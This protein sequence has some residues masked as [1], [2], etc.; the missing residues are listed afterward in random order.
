AGARLGGMLSPFMVMLGEAVGLFLAWMVSGWVFGLIAGIVSVGASLLLVRA[1]PGARLA[2]LLLF[3]GGAVVTLQAW[4]MGYAYADDGGWSECQCGNI[5]DWFSSAGAGAVI[6]RG[7]IGG[8]GAAA[9]ALF[10]A[11]VGAG[12]AGLAA[13]TAQANVVGPSS[14]GSGQ[15]QYRSSAADFDYDSTRTLGQDEARGPET[16]GVHG[17][18]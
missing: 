8:V 9:G 13:A 17:D 15:Q 7:A 5:F 16:A 2:S 14:G 6:Q 1:T 18:A 10:G 4:R 11:G 3:A 12:A